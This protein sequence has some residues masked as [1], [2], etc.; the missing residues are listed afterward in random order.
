MFI[1]P[2]TKRLVAEDW[3]GDAVS[4]VGN[5]G[6]R[7]HCPGCYVAMDRDSDR[8]VVRYS[9]TQ[10][11]KKC[12]KLDLLNVEECVRSGEYHFITGTAREQT[13]MRCWREIIQ[14]QLV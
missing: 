7:L 12:I 2:R 10:R 6:L 5:M 4:N 13:K 3:C 1:T 9:K 11:E 8:S 14:L